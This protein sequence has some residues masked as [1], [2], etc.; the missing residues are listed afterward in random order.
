MKALRLFDTNDEKLRQ[1]ILYVSQKCADQ[2]NFGS[3]KLNKILYFSD[4]L[5]YANT[6][7]PITGAEYQRLD[8]GPAPR[9]MKPVLNDLERDSEL[10]MQEVQ[11]TGNYT[12]KKPVNL[13]PPNLGVFSAA[14]IAIV[15]DVIEKFEELT[16]NQTSLFS[17]DWGGWKYAADRGTIPYES[18]FISHKPLEPGEQERGLEIAGAHGLLDG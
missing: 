18:V 9:K 3:T 14:E 2:K 1:L 12:S 13:V 10:A 11:L 7:E 4:F 6:G 17:H 16:A 5:A 8:W 15:D